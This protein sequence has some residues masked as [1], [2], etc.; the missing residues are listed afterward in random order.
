MSRTEILCKAGILLCVFAATFYTIDCVWSWTT[1]WPEEAEEVVWLSV[2]S[3][4]MGDTSISNTITAP[5]FASAAMDLDWAPVPTYDTL[6]N[7][8]VYNECAGLT[9]DFDDEGC[10][11]VDWK[12]EV[13]GRCYSFHGATICA[14]NRVEIKQ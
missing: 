1:D 11:L 3:D 6:I 5:S 10:L 12:A 13:D 9:V 14:D 2:E 7:V 8:V 4:P